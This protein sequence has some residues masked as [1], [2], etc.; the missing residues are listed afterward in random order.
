VETALPI[1][2]LTLAVVVLVLQILTL[3]KRAGD[4]LDLAP[5]SA[6]L[7]ALE[8]AQERTERGLREEVGR[9]RDESSRAANELRQGVQGAVSTLSAGVR[10]EIGAAAA[11]QKAQLEVF[12]NQLHRLSQ[13]VTERLDQ[14]RG[15][16][17]T[18]T[19]ALRTDLTENLKSF[20]TSVVTN[21]TAMSA[22]QNQ[23]LARLTEAMGLKLDG[24]RAVV[25]ERL[26]TL[27]E[28]NALRLEKIRQTVDEQ[29]QS[30]LEKRLGESFKLVSDRLDQVHRGL[31]EMQNLAAGV[32]DLKKVLTNVRTR[33]TWGELQLGMLLEQMLTP[34]Q[35]EAN[36]ATTGTNERVEFAIKLPGG[37]LGE[38]VWLFIDAKFPKEDYERLLQA[39][40][41]ADPAGV[42]ES[43][44]QLEIRIRQEARDIATKYL[45]PPK[46]TDFGVMY[47]PTE[48]LYAEVLR[49]PGLT[50][51]LQ[52]EHR[53]TVAGPMTLAAILNSLQMGFRTLAIQKRSGEVWQV[54]GA[55][56]TEFGKYA[57]ILAKVQKKL[58]EAN[59]TVDTGLRKTRTIQKKLRK[60]EAVSAAAAEP[61]LL[62]EGEESESDGN[63]GEGVLSSFD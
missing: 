16:L 27:Q 44:K 30:T 63:D 46:T 31:G 38:H 19:Q 10:D 55:I 36:V 50:E 21:L 3:R 47:L 53:V 60:V 20:S 15:E 39:V 43:S 49:R 51:A 61:A 62:I 33:G 17:L 28:D 5:L 14:S 59:N 42:E 12:G 34:D 22:V 7:E 18:A 54:L 1:A 41:R 52:R 6:R 25:D 26:K 9:N 37:E 4:G 45:A 2:A 56:K 48:G 11:A 40:E 29:L 58:Q 35:Y 32:G 13:T 23:E 8:R 57:D 24:V